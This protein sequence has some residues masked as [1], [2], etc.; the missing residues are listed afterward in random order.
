MEFERVVAC[1]KFVL[2]KQVPKN[3]F[4]L[5]EL[6]QIELLFDDKNC[7]VGINTYHFIRDLQWNNMETEINAAPDSVF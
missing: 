2:E 4:D 5:E 1:W 3:L 7:P 6:H